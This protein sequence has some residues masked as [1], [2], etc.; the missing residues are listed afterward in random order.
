ETEDERATKGRAH[1]VASAGEWTSNPV[2]RTP[3]QRSTTSWRSLHAAGNSRD[4]LH[5]RAAGIRGGFVLD[6]VKT[7][8]A[9]VNHTTELRARGRAAPLSRPRRPRRLRTA[10]GAAPRPRAAGRAALPRAG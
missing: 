1:G 9:V 5:G 8:K 2:E 6:A 4:G 7:V 10:C 3:G